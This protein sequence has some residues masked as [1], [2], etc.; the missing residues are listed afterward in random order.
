MKVLQANLVN[1][2]MSFVDQLLANHALQKT[3]Y[4]YL[5]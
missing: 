1:L 2:I 5:K 3:F 4:A